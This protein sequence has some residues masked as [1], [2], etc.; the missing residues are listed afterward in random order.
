M[1]AVVVM[2]A[3]DS[4]D[5]T[6]LPLRL[7]PAAFKLSPVTLPVTISPC[8]TVNPSSIVIKLESSDLILLVTSCGATTVLITDRLPPVML[9]L[10]L[11]PVAFKLPPVT[12]PVTDSVVPKIALAAVMLPPDMLAVVVMLPVA[13]TVPA[14]A[15]LPPS[16]LPDAL[17]VTPCISALLNT[18]PPLRLAIEVMLPVALMI[19]PVSM[20]P[21]VMLAVVVTGPVSDTKLPVYVGKYAAT[22]ESP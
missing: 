9:P 19:P 15:I 10:K 6:T 5:D 16:M 12:L 21:P 22:L 11:K 20:L 1:F 7:N 18:L 8:S 2:L 14:V 3:V 4:R 17:K 13:V